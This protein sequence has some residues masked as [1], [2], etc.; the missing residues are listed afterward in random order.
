MKKWLTLFVC[1]VAM[2][3]TISHAEDGPTGGL[4]L[5]EFSP[6]LTARALNVSDVTFSYGSLQTGVAATFSATG[7]GE[8]YTYCLAVAVDWSESYQCIYDSMGDTEFTYTFYQPGEQG[9]YAIFALDESGNVDAFE[10]LTVGGKDYLDERLNEIVAKC[11]SGD[12]YTRALWLHDYLA[13][14][15]YYDYSL[16]YHGADVLLMKGYGVC[17][18]YSAAYRMLLGKLGIACDVVEAPAMSHAWNAVK[19]NGSW[20]E[21]DVTWDTPGKGTGSSGKPAGECGHTYFALPSELM[22]YNHYGYTRTDCN[23]M[24]DNYFVRSG[25]AATWLEQ[26]LADIETAMD[27]MDASVLVTLETV[28]FSEWYSS[29]R[30]DIAAAAVA[31]VLNGMEYENERKVPCILGASHVPSQRGMMSLEITVE[32]AYDVSDKAVLPADVTSVGE[33]AFDGASF[34]CVRL[35]EGMTDIGSRAFADNGLLAYVFIPDTVVSIADDAFAGCP[36]VSIITSS[37]SAAEA[38]AV[39]N[40]MDYAIR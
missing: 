20:Y 21:V 37:D 28:G 40:G 8:D 33:G 5:I 36:Y 4:R 30:Q 16:R 31:C 24:A 3:I 2:T 12:D 25:E 27:G 11:P 14:G 6:R 10:L 22:G 1:L 17:Q 29:S 9:T 39:R 38:W 32:V 26:P 13:S 18:S 19:L 34:V 23:S 15:T 7:G 35:P